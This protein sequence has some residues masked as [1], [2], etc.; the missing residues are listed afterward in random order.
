MAN[1]T[2]FIHKADPQKHIDKDD[3]LFVIYSPRNFRHRYN[4]VYEIN[5]IIELIQQHRPSRIVINCSQFHAKDIVKFI[6]H[7]RALKIYR[8]SIDR[9]I[10]KNDNDRIIT[11]LLKFM[12]I[13]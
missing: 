4:R 5:S 12:I 13:V 9:V 10:Y 7:I 1:E 11:I 6:F 3:D 8:L 2:V